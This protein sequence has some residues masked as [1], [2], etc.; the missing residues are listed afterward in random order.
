MVENTLPVVLKGFKGSCYHRKKCVNLALL[1]CSL[2]AWIS[3]CYRPLELS[4]MM[5]YIP[6]HRSESFIKNVVSI[7]RMHGG[8]LESRNVVTRYLYWSTC[9]ILPGST[10]YHFLSSLVTVVF[11]STSQLEHGLFQPQ[12]VS[13]NF[14]PFTL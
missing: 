3:V 13:S 10:I 9:T 14:K 5:G 1:C 2:V 12:R 6:L 7:N 8:N 11:R 4:R